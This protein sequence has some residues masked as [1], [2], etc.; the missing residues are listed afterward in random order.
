MGWE[1]DSRRGW[2]LRAPPT[3]PTPE[4]PLI[5]VLFPMP[6]PSPWFWDG[7]EEAISLE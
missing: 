2:G 6:V 3:E 1:L 7:A 5:A 4:V